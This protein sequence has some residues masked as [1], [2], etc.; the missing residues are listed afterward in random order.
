LARFFSQNESRRDFNQTRPI[1]NL[2]ARQ[3]S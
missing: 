2:R 3:A 1:A